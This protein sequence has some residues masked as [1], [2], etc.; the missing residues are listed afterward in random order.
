MMLGLGLIE[1]RSNN[2]WFEEYRRWGNIPDR[3]HFKQLWGLSVTINDTDGNNPY[4]SWR[5]LEGKLQ[6]H[7]LHFLFFIMAQAMSF[8]GAA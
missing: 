3:L 8:F 4:A 6:T 1:A 7:Q 2:G 5:Y